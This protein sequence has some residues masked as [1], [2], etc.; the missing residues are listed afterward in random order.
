MFLRY[1]KSLHERTGCAPQASG[2]TGRIVQL[3]TNQDTSSRGVGG[4]FL[5]LLVPNVYPKMTVLT[6]LVYNLEIRG[7]EM[8]G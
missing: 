5:K 4:G 8:Y 6:G 1:F 7:N 3:I 2:E